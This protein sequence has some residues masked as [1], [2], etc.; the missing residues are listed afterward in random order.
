MKRCLFCP[1]PA[2]SLEHVI[3][4]WVHCIVSPLSDGAFP[5]QVGRYFEN[6]GYRDRRE[7]ISL[8]FKSRVVCHDCNT[9]WM[10]KLENEMKGTLSQLVTTPFPPLKSIDYKRFCACA[11]RIALWLAKTA[12]TTST[13]LPGKERL[14]ISLTNTLD[15]KPP[16]HAWVDLAVSSQPGVGAALT[17][18]FLT[19]NGNEP[20]APRTHT[21]SGC[22]QFCIQVN[23][24]LLRIGITPNAMVDYI[25]PASSVPL[26]LFPRPFPESHV[27][28]PANIEY[29]NLNHFLH[30]VRLRT[31]A[32]CPGE[33]PVPTS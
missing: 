3:P 19:M 18:T 15:Q 31:W 28:I 1:N 22:F 12:L 23:H 8:A 24:L 4:T 10:C 25:P 32:G 5:V 17:K 6:D 20:I 21:A 29:E 26:R 30:G 16:S 7:Q 33:V 9:G 14:P 27:T 13:A 2:N 11:P